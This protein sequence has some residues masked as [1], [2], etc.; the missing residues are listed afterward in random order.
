MPGGERN[1]QSRVGKT[2]VGRVAILNMVGSVTF[3]RSDTG[4]E[5]RKHNGARHGDPLGTVFGHTEPPMRNPN[6]QRVRRGL[7]VTAG[8]LKSSCL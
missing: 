6:A 1:K 5:T 2:Q 3:L 7:P 8:S 4:A